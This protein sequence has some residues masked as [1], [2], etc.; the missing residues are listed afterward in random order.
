MD[1]LQYINSVYKTERNDRNIR[2]LVS[3][4]D[5]RVRQVLV[6]Q[7]VHSMQVNGKIL[8]IL[9]STQK[10]SDVTDFY[11]FQV[12]NPL[13]GEVNLCNDFFE[14]S[15]LEEI[16]RLRS[17][18]TD[19]GFEET[20][21]MKVVNYLS[22]VRETERRLGNN[23]PLGIEIFEEYA[24]TALVKWKL[25]KLVESGKLS[26]E[27]Y[28]YLLI[29][30]AEISSAA[31]DFEMFLMLLAPFLGG[32]CLPYPGTAIHLPI[33]EFVSDRPIQEVLCKLMLSFIKRQQESCSVLVIDD[34]KC[35]RDCIIDVLKNLP[36]ATEVHMF[37][38]DAFSLS[39]KEIGI[40]M[41]TF[42]VR[43]YSRHESMD[44]CSKIETCCG[45]ID[46]IKRSYTTTIDKRIRMSTAFDMLLGTNRTEAEIRNAPVREARY[47]KEM[48]HSLDIGTAI[49]DCGGTQVLF[50]F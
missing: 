19:F 42:P 39:D 23:A 7:I 49:I 25:Q 10:G 36:A 29:R 17:L 11:G 46:V 28:E 50:Q 9:D 44:S 5:F 40:L 15:S 31:A 2:Y 33:G 12:L 34:G 45:D 35:D 18:L 26:D 24:G 43:I 37:S 21:A 4:V 16:S 48:I 14:M 20:K 1:Y 27:S 41:S 8:F 22:F 30:Y 13:K 32:T 47:R 38:R 6:Q 3:G